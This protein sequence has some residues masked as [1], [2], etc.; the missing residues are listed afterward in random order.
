VDPNLYSANSEFEFTGILKL[1]APKQGNI[2]LIVGH[3]PVI[4]AAATVYSGERLQFAPAEFL[5][6]KQIAESW[7][8]ALESD[9]CWEIARP[10]L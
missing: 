1:R 5:I 2:M 4:S 8:V 3:N 10:S 6:L 7:D 9:G